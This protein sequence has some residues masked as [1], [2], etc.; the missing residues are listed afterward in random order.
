M[1]RCDL[2]HAQNDNNLRI[3]LMLEGTVLLDV[4]P[5]KSNKWVDL[6]N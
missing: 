5:L 4:A 1:T 3:L 2:V 6:Q